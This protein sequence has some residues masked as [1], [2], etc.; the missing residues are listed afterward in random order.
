MRIST[1]MR[2]LV[3]YYQI[4][5]M[6]RSGEAEELFGQNLLGRGDLPEPRRSP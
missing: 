4:T 6:V 2:E 3:Y 1:I 5:T